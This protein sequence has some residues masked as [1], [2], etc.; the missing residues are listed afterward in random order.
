MIK[1]CKKAMKIAKGIEGFL[2]K[3]EVPYNNCLLILA[4][5][6]KEV[7]L[8]F[9]KEEDDLFSDLKN[10]FN[11]MSLIKAIENPE[12]GITVVG[13]KNESNK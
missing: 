10:S 4:Q 7:Q 13:L 8:N 1:D 6:L 9:E 3:D 11:M 5:V 2:R 12:V